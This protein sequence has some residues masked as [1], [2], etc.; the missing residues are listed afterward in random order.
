M[1]ITR[2]IAAA[3]LT[4][5]IAILGFC[6]KSGIDNFVEKDRLVTVKGLAEKEVSANLVTWPIV[7]KEIG[8]DLP[9]LYAK[10]NSTTESIK[11]FLKAGGLSD[12]E[13]SVNAPVVID[14]NAERYGGNQSAYRY[15]ITSVITVTSSKVDLVRQILA[16]QGELLKDGIAIVSGDFENPIRYDYTGLVDIKG[17]MMDEA[18]KNASATA[19]QFANVSKSKL[20]RIQSASQGQFSVE[21]RDAYTPYIKKIR[22]VTTITY[23]LKD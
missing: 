4:V 17:E 1:N 18:I 3:I 7:S 11:K 15:N 21:D 19:Q 2:I 16:R 6:L 14:M 9:T 5:G 22:V 12:Q 8:D 23:S 13:I 10:M 20:S